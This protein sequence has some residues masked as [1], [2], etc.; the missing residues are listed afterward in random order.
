MPETP[1]CP[2]LVAKGKH[3]EALALLQRY[4]G[5]GVVTPYVAAEYA[6][7]KACSHPFPAGFRDRWRF[8]TLVNKKGD[9]HRLFL[10]ESLYPFAGATPGPRDAIQSVEQISADS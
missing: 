4:H 9:G 8:D 1:D 2:R 10:G 7:M 5:S 3:N 6:E